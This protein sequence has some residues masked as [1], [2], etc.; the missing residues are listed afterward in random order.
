[1]ADKLTKEQRHR[2]MAAI[3]GKNTKPELIV[4]KFL[5]GLGFRYRLHHSKLPGHPDLVLKKYKTVIFINGCFWHGHIDCKSYV[6]PKSNVEYWENKIQR[7]KRR[8]TEVQR[9]IA[10]MGWHCITIW[11]CQ[12]KPKVREQTLEALVNTLHHI[13]MKDR[14]PKDYEIPN[15]DYVAMA[16]EAMEEY[17]V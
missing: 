8:D 10:L 17:E 13:Y 1:M 4:R 11:E 15:E 12:L 6:L 5:F 7:N 2:C 3:K 16:A 9:K 14:K